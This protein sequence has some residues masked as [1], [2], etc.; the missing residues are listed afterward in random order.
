MPQSIQPQFIQLEAADRV[1]VIRLNR[2]E[3]L[4]AWNAPMREEI[5]Q[6]LLA[7]DADAAIGAIIMTG[8]GDR[9][10]C[11]GQ[12][13]EEA[14]SFDADRAEAWMR[15]WERY[16]GVLRGLSK[17]LIMALNGITGGSAFQVALL[18]D[19]RVAHPGVTIGQPE[20]KQ[21]IASV[22]GPWIMNTMLGMSRTIE[23]T[24][25]GRMMQADE[26]HRLGIIHHIVPAEQVMAK[27]REIALELAS[28]PPVAMR[29]TKQRFREMT[30]AS[31]RDAID[32]GIRIQ[33]ESFISGEPARMMEEFYKARGSKVDLKP[34]A[35]A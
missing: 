6:A 17:P 32:A 19:I 4:N 12:D 8:A 26:A 1:A 5:V 10:F 18:G 24:L 28:R 23:L 20:I 27:A 13:L 16:Y 2:P 21:G 30:E 14:H 11:A 9:A 3:K 25:M 22:T 33:R 31:F 15:E 35:A 29:L 34:A 7:F